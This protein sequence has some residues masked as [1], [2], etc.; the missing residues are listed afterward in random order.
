MATYSGTIPAGM[1]RISLGI[2]MGASEY[3]TK[4]TFSQNGVEQIQFWHSTSSDGS[5]T[6]YLEDTSGNNSQYIGS[7]SGSGYFYFTC[8]DFDGQLEISVHTGAVPLCRSIIVFVGALPLCRSISPRIKA[9][10]SLLYFVS[11]ELILLLFC[12][13]LVGNPERSHEV[14]HIDR[15]NHT[16]F[17]TVI[18]MAECAYRHTGIHIRIS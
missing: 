1:G 5:V 17:F 7:A 12:I 10:T 6:I 3:P 15:Q 14:A 11:L 8:Q 2:T 9:L 16:G 4:I 18:L 13:F